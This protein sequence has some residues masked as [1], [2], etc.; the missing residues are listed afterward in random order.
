MQGSNQKWTIQ[1]TK[2]AATVECRFQ[3]QSRKF[4]VWQ[5][6]PL[7]KPHHHRHYTALGWPAAI[8]QGS[9]TNNSNST[10]NSNT[11]CSSSSS[12]STSNS[13]ISNSTNSIRAV[14]WWWAAKV[15]LWVWIWQ[16][17]LTTKVW[18]LWAVVWWTIS[19]IPLIPAMGGF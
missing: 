8:T 12:N 18:G 13:S 17:H 5:T 1:K 19:G 10:I 3:P 14:G 11:I 9:T 2:R 7:A 16:I 15:P 4:G 6:Q